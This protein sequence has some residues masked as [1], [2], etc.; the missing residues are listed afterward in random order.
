MARL[1]DYLLSHAAVLDPVPLVAGVEG[2]IGFTPKPGRVVLKRAGSRE[3]A[4]VG[5]DTGDRK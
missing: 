5:T 4:R 2:F 1:L 3:D